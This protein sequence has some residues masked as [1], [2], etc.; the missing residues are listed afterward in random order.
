M[1]CTVLTDNRTSNP[2]LTTEHGL[3]LL[4]ETDQTQVL[5]DTG[6]SDVFLRNAQTLG[7]DLSRVPYVFLS[8]AHA[9]H[10]G[11]LEA[12]LKH[13]Q[14]ARILVS[15]QSVQHQYYSKRG[16]LHSITPQWPQEAMRNRTQYID[17]TQTLADGLA[18]LAHL[19]QQH[20]MPQ[21]NNNLLIEQEG[22]LVADTFR[23]ELA[24]YTH[25]FL[26]TGC[27]HNG[28]ENILSACPWPLHTVVGGFHLLDA[29]GTAH[30]ESDDQLTALATR[31]QKNYPHTQ[32]YTSHCTGDH[33]FSVLQRTLGAQ[34][35]PFSCGTV[36][37]C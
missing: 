23:H 31:L 13:N 5:L 3:S 32:F 6:A 27:A 15:P 37:E 14:Q 21:G 24:L 7:L 9:D 20:P 33:A 11:G 10:T 28:L 16:G 22:S 34:L 8:H 1:K 4:L 26:F 12:L 2:A 25:G 35:Q 36:I 19:P 30:Y 29:S 18:V 17:Q